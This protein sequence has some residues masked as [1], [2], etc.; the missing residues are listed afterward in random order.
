MSACPGCDTAIIDERARFC[1]GCGARLDGATELLPI[2]DSDGNS[3]DSRSNDATGELPV[4]DAT[5]ETIGLGI[6]LEELAIE[7]R[8]ETA[9][10]Q[11]FERTMGI[12][13][14]EMQL[15]IRPVE[16]ADDPEDGDATP[17]SGWTPDPTAATTAMP[18]T[19]SGGP[20]GSSAPA[21]NL[22]DTP[23][24]GITLDAAQRA[25]LRTQPVDEVRDPVL[26]Q[27]LD[28]VVDQVVDR[29]VD[30]AARNV[31][32]T[33]S[34]ATSDTVADTVVN[35]VVNTVVSPAIDPIVTPAVD[36][37]DVAHRAPTGLDL[38]HDSRRGEALAGP[39]PIG[40][41]LR[42]SAL[43]FIAIVQ[44]AV[45]LV[46]MTVD[47]V[48][49]SSTAS[50]ELAP[51]ATSLG[52]R[53]GVWHVEHLGSNLAIAG[54]IA[55]IGLAIG[56][57]ASVRRLV[58]G[59]GLIGGSALASTGVTALAIGLAEYPV[60]A[61]RAFA[62]AATTEAFTVTIVRGLGYWS[63][64]AAA[65]IGIIGF[66]GAVNEMFLDRDH[67]L[68]PWVAAFGALA[69]VLAALA[70][71]VPMGETA[72][73]AN[74]VIGTG[75]GTWPTELVVARLVQT[76]TVAVGGVFG[77]LIVRRFGLGM[78]AGTVSPGL[79]LALSAWIGLG[80]APVGP[81]IR[82]PG[83]TGGG[84]GTLTVAGY[85]TVAAV[86]AAAGAIAWDH[87]QHRT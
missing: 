73:S 54:L 11:Q 8:R 52:M 77:F 60:N 61:A 20:A 24:R 81:A 86:L 29:V 85:V 63:L 56:V 1:N 78:I 18:M 5:A 57:V 31:D 75:S 46:A 39:S 36:V 47:V 34:D 64:L 27:V 65:A 44:T 50:E 87:E 17:L 76:G 4:H 9:E 45:L 82:N 14:D 16:W 32:D 23:V 33:A 12:P 19:P 79:W 40:S 26:D 28:Q 74:W 66:F 41:G 84:V 69:V 67:D 71:L 10:T 49:I 51:I 59:P 43:S 35:T 37:L 42:F 70:P 83:A 21:G 53:V 13:A 48:A 62:S 7:R 6:H 72:W 68:N 3:D 30:P 2:V 15:I 58:W 55:A 38:E 25:E 22:D 80:A